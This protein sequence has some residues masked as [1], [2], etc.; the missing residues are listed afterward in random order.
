[1]PL[2]SSSFPGAVYK[3][4]ARWQ[5]YALLLLPPSSFGLNVSLK[6][7]F[8]SLQTPPVAPRAL[9]DMRVSSLTLRSC[10]SLTHCDRRPP[11]REHPISPQVG[12]QPLHHPTSP[13]LGA[14]P[15]PHPIRR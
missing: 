14:L 8:A 1:M 6:S 2:W 5:A 11:D 4:P 9:T 7:I 12:H 13:P 10:C 15:Q 3:A